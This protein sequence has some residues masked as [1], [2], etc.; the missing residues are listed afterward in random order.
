[1]NDIEKELEAEVQKLINTAFDEEKS[2]VD[3]SVKYK[4]VVC[5]NCKESKDWYSRGCF[6][7]GGRKWRDNEGLI[8]NGKLCGTCNRNRAG[9]TM[10]RIRGKDV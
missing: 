10:R 4:T 6:P 3:T 8:C 2:P 1:M 7:N 5:K 9:K